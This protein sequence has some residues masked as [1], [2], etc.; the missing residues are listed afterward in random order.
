[1]EQLTAERAA[2]L[3]AFANEH[4]D[5]TPTPRAH[6]DRA[7]GVVVIRS[8]AVLASGEHVIESD[9]VR[10]LSQLRAVLGY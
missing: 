6:F 9:T 7:A 10:S 3:V 1:M 8:T 4:D 5:G 2:K